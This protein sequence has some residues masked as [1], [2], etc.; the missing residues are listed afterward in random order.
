LI[1]LPGRRVSHLATARAGLVGP[2]GL[3]SS[4]GVDLLLF[5]RHGLVPETDTAPRSQ[6]RARAQDPFRRPR[7]DPGPLEGQKRAPYWQQAAELLRY[8][9]ENDKE[10]IDDMRAQLMRALYTDGFV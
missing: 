9:A 8:A 1:K 4:G 6:R 5:C 3:F 7:D 10:A 2:V